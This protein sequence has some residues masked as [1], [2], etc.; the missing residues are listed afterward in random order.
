[1]ANSRLEFDLLLEHTIYQ[2]HKAGDLVQL[3]HQSLVIDLSASQYVLV[4]NTC[5]CYFG[6]D[7]V[8]S[9]AFSHDVA[10][11][12]KILRYNGN[13]IIQADGCLYKLGRI[14]LTKFVETPNI[15]DCFVLNKQLYQ[16]ASATLFQ[17][18]NNKFKFV[19]FQ[20]NEISTHQFCD[21]VYALESVANEHDDIVSTCLLRVN[22]DISKTKVHEIPSE[23]VR[24]LISANGVLVIDC[25]GRLVF[26]DMLHQ[27]IVEGNS[28]TKD[29]SQI[30]ACLELGSNGLQLKQ[31]VLVD[32]F[33]EQYPQQVHDY[34]LSYNAKTQ[35]LEP[36]TKLEKCQLM[37]VLKPLPYVDLYTAVEDDTFYVV[38]RNM[39]VLR[40]FPVNCEIYA[41]YRNNLL[42]NNMI[43]FEGSLYQFIICKGVMYIQIVNKIYYLSNGQFVFLLEI[44]NFQFQ[45]Q[46]AYYSCLFA[47]DDQIYISNMNK[48]FVFANNVLRLVNDQTAIFQHNIQ[49]YNKVFVFHSQNDLLKIFELK[50]P[51]EILKINHFEFLSFVERNR[52]YNFEGQ[53]ISSG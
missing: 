14:Q 27:R 28:H 50:T 22:T 20:I 11:V 9:D 30:N 23:E 19:N 24:G 8:V 35:L 31:H 44:P 45:N 5:C 1:M 15:K 12:R 3:T 37:H 25:N 7:L 17:F 2:I 33:G 34:L 4:T 38:D 40:R 18:N 32:L 47:S 29:I 42:N 39:N 43:I 21:L 52:P 36:Q 10:S 6:S 26:F 41:G 53:K 49:F 16:I 46:A 13:I 48:I 51:H